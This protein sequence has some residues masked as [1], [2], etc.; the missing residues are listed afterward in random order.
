[1][2]AE[3]PTPA[4]MRANGAA[5]RAI[6]ARQIGELSAIQNKTQKQSADLERLRVALPRIEAAW[7]PTARV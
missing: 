6:L 3:N 4:E 1:M 5:V 7:Q 2:S